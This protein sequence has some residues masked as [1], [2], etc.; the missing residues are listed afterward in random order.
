MN[1]K[2]LV[3]I[4]SLV[5]L[6]SFQAKIVA[7]ESGLS[8]DGMTTEAGAENTLTITIPINNA[9]DSLTNLQ[10]NVPGEFNLDTAGE[11]NAYIVSG[12][13]E[14][15]K[16]N[17]TA[18]V[19]EGTVTF[20]TISLAEFALAEESTLEIEIPEVQNPSTAGEFT[21]SVSYQNLASELVMEDEVTF[22]IQHEQEQ[23]SD[24]ET[25]QVD[26]QLNMNVGEKL[27][28]K[29]LGVKEDGTTVD[30][31][32]RVDFALSSEALLTINADGELSALAKGEAAITVSLNDVQEQITVQITS[33]SPEE[34]EEEQ[35][36]GN[37]SNQQQTETTGE[38]DKEEE[39]VTPGVP[40]TGDGSSQSSNIVDYLYYILALTLA[41]FLGFRFMRN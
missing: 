7:A 36:E 3:S 13:G 17:V 38:S 6:L 18:I 21:F 1:R 12:S 19:K 9:I 16:V 11:V 15:E 27:Q 2:T 35:Q 39:L 25:L 34:N 41:G 40:D 5:V 14:K 4:I 23:E 22:A 29:V 10:V 28:L 31:T 26:S 37:H 30:V 32:D 24:I 33:S 20:D 8:M